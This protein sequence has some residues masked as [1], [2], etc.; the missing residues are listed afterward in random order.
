MDPS[1]LIKLCETL[2]LSETEPFY[3][4]KGETKHVGA[5][6]VSHSLMGKVLSS[7]RV[8]REA[9]IGVIEQLWSPFGRVEIEVIADNIFVFYF[10]NPEVRDMI[11]ARS[12]W[13]FDNNLIVLEKPQGVGEISSLSFHTAEMWV[14]IHNLP[15]M[16][17][18][19]RAA[20]EI[21]EQIG[22]VVEIPA[23]SKECR[24]R[25][26]RVKVQID[27]SK[28]L[29][30]FIKPGMDESDK[31]IVAPLLYERLP[32]FCYACGKIGHALKEC[33]DDIA[34]LEAL[35][36]ARGETNSNSPRKRSDRVESGDSI[37]NN[38]E[39]CGD[40]LVMTNRVP[41]SDFGQPVDLVKHHHCSSGSQ[42]E[43]AQME[44]DKVDL[45]GNPE[46]NSKMEGVAAYSEDIE[47]MPP[48]TMSVSSPTNPTPG[49]VNVRKWKRIARGG[50]GS[51]LGMSVT[52]PMHRL[53]A[54]SQ[55][56]SRTS[57]V[58]PGNQYP[59]NLS[60]GNHTP[61]P[62]TVGTRESKRKG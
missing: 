23:E 16:C 55:S 24:G 5:S 15:L 6:D 48:Q 38:P 42:R 61:S 1:E 60:L 36:V 35:E 3:L 53:L 50:Q 56:H 13:H 31:V 39:R 45:L 21:T 20:K 30:R 25:F 37:Q 14:Q 46:L 28:P 22:P 7:K 43:V 18:N 47:S 2:S 8:N 59:P 51:Q 49:E 17:M 34:K 12:P 4:I 32:E 54:A 26:L 44:V 57:S 41:A 19:R 11:W 27:V 52:S 58:N 62:E 29:K 33:T 9:F 40:E 10:N